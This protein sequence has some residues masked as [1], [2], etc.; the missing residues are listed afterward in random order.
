MLTSYTPFTQLSDKLDYPAK[1]AGK[2]STIHSQIISYVV[3]H[4]ERKQLFKNLVLSTMNSMSYYVFHGEAIPDNWDP[5]DPLKVD[6]VDPDKCASLPMNISY[7]YVDWSE[8]DNKSLEDAPA[9]APIKSVETPKIDPPV[10]KVTKETPKEDLY[11]KPPLIPKFATSTYASGSIAGERYCIYDSIPT[12]PVKQNEISATTDVMRMTDKDLMRL[13]PNR[14]IPTRAASMYSRIDGI[15][16]HEQL[17]VVL[18]VDGYSYEDRVLNIIQYPH[19]YRLLKCVG[20]TEDGFYSTI[21]IDGELHRTLDIWDSLPE[22]AVIPKN[23]EFIKEYVIR[24]YLLERDVSKIEHKY[25]LYG[26]LD[27]FLTLF[28]TP[29]EYAKLGFPNSVELARMCV[30]RRVNFKRSRNPV[31]RRLENA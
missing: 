8:L 26:A 9:A 18:P 12:I 6:K 22:S 28:T 14:F 16:Y 21:E 1:I 10:H 7:K 17:G 24:R 30:A 15:D 27:P 5:D 2:L 20:D 4:Y 11:L 3:D 25:K 31:L 19:L 13:F 23:S 29:E